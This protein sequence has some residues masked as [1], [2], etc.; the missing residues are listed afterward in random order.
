MNV[1][2]QSG[3]ARVIASGS[4]T[5]FLGEGLVLAILADDQRYALELDFSSDPSVADVAIETVSMEH[6]LRL[7]CVNFDTADGRGSAVPVALGACGDDVVF[8]HFRVFRYGRT[9]DRTVH[10]TFF[11]AP[12]SVLDPN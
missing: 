9:A 12:R 1:E 6:G 3:S 11:R 2:I 8:V 7:H 10:Y 5:C 4:A